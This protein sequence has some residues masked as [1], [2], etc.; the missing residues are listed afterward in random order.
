MATLANSSSCTFCRSVRCRACSAYKVREHV[1]TKFSIDG[2]PAHSI[3]SLEWKLQSKVKFVH[4]KHVFGVM[5][6]IIGVLYFKM[7]TKAVSVS[8]GFKFRDS[9]LSVGR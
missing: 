9:W 6:V 3:L 4:L 7:T 5:F 8:E 2:I 1:P